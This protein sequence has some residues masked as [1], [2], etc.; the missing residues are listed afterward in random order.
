[1][2]AGNMLGILQQEPSKWFRGIGDL[3]ESEIQNLLDSRA[4]A[5]KDKNFELAD[6]IRDKLTAMK[7]QIHDHPDG[8]S[9]WRK[10]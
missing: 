4:K 5:K 3:D 7:I 6:G 2:A 9:S 1:M 10:L 8:T